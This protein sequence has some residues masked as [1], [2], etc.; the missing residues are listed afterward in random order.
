MKNSW[1]GEGRPGH[2]GELDVVERVD[3]V[4]PGGRYD[5]RS[6]SDRFYSAATD[7]IPEVYRF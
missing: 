3:G 7:F 4:G 1:E 5:I 2:T 6:P